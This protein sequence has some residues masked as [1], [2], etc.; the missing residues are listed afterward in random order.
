MA[1]DTTTETPV[2]KARRLVAGASAPIWRRGNDRD[3]AEVRTF[4]GRF[5]ADCGPRDLNVSDQDADLIAAAPQLLADLANVAEASGNTCDLLHGQLTESR[6]QVDRWRD[7][8]RRLETELG[9]LIGAAQ[10][11]GDGEFLEACINASKR[12]LWTGPDTEATT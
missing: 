10:K 2:E 4:D 3:I 9:H 5:V 11:P 1:A 7:Y 8:A 6:N 12:V